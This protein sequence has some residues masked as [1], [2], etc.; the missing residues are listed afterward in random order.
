MLPEKKV[1]KETQVLKVQRDKLALL[2][3]R[4]QLDKPAQLVQPE[5]KAIKETQV[6]KVQRDKLAQQDRKVQS[7]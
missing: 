3:L 6:L 4:A 2:V 1:I 7:D 5:Q